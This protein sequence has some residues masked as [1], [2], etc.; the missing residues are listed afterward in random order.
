M[1][2]M[3]K[4]ATIVYLLICILLALKG[5]TAKYTPDWDSIDSRP[6]PDWYDKAKFGIFLHWGVFSVP[7]FHNEWFWPQ[8]KS[9]HPAP[10]IVRFMKQNYRPDF[11]YADFAADFTAEFFN[12][13]EWADIFKASGAGY[14][15]L[16]S[17]HGEGFPN[18]P[19]SH[20]FNWN[21][22]AVGPNRDLV[23]DL[24]N[25]IRNK[26]D[27]KFGTYYCISEWLH[28]LY[29]KDKA[30]N[31]TTQSFVLSK[32]LPELYELV[33]R[34]KPE[35]LWADLADGQ[36]P[37]S[38]YKSKEFLA[39][40]YNDSPVKDSVVTNDR[41]CHEC[42]CKHGGY[43]TCRDKWNPGK[44]QKYKWEDCMSVDKY[45]WGYRRNAPLDSYLDINQIIS[46]FAST[47]S[48]GGNML[49][50]IGPT[51]EGTIIPVFEERL[52]QFGS[53]LKINGEGVYGSVPWSHQNDFTT[54]NVWYTQQKTENDDSMV[55]AIMLTWPDDSV[56]MLGAP[57]PSQST[58]VTM[59]GYEGTV[60]WKAGPGG[61]GMNITLSNIP[62][63]KLPSPWAW[64]FKLTNIAN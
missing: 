26:T 35:I 53:W 41:W 9:R 59:L 50:N 5:I 61:Q 33:N 63:N 43:K 52:R 17:K 60:N 30:N 54:K 11:T 15:V 45:S 48:C 40:L 18:W 62:W 49:M 36:G 19:S 13:D 21:A 32:A 7:S 22:K 64:M 14:V 28:P 10:D 47:I 38:Y 55:Y 57:I 24:A 27:L 51:K 6:L 2:K 12:P 25:A 37:A 1:I 44:L 4:M 20:S 3:M 46:T 16:T 39:W 23:G 8:W 29:M 31:F 42:F 58:Q 56:L 34:Y